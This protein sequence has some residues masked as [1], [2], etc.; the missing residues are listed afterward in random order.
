[1]SEQWTRVPAFRGLRDDSS[2]F[3]STS[4]HGR[5]YVLFF[6]PRANS[7]GCTREAK[8]FA[9]IAPELERA[10]VS[11][12]GVSVDPASAQR[13]FAERCRLPFPLIADADRA[14][15]RSFGVLGAFG[16]ARRVTYLVGADGELLETVRSPLPKEH[17]RRV[18]ARFLRSGEGPVSRGTVAPSAADVAARENLP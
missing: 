8:G 13:S 12:V 14:V 9:E 15:A 11:L 4:L 7:L 2:P 5:P 3:D 1:M 6:Y 18:V 17:V 10:G 16:V